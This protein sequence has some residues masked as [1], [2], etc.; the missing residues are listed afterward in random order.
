[1]LSDIF[2]MP[3]Y[4]AFIHSEKSHIVILDITYMEEMYK[5]VFN[6]KVQRGKGYGKSC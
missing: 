1:M 6:N 2:D 3:F 4:F 5:S